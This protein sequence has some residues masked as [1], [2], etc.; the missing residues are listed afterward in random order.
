MGRPVGRW[1]CPIVASVLLGGCYTG[2]EQDPV[3][4]A[5]PDEGGSDSDGTDIPA[6][7]EPA[8]AA[9]RLL[10]QRQHEHAIAD[11]LGPEAAAAASPPPNIALNGFDTVGASQQALSDAEVDAFEESAR[12]VAQAADAAGRLG[13]WV[14]CDPAAI[15]DEA[16]MQEV[17]RGFGRSAWRRALSDEEVERYAAVGTSAAADLGSFGLGVRELIAAMLQS[18]HFIYQVEIGEPDPGD[19]SVRRLTAYEM[20]ARVSFF[21]VDTIPDEELLTDAES[22]LLDDSEGIRDATWRLLARAEARDSVSAFFSELWRLRE[23]DDLPKDT[24]AFPQWTPQLAEAMRGETVALIDDLVWNRDADFREVFTADYTFAD[25]RLGFH[26]GLP[27]ASSLGDELQRVEL[28]GHDKRGGL[29]GHA[30]FQALLAHVSTT[31]PTL[32]GKFVLENVLCQSVP[33]PPPE[34]ITELPDTSDAKTM[35]ERL[36]IHMSDPSCAGCHSVID[37][38]GFG[39]ENYDAIGHFRTTEN[40][41]TIDAAS[42]LYGEDFEGAAQLGAIIADS[43]LAAG[44]LVRN[45]YRHA[46]GHIETDGERVAI[47]ELEAA[48]IDSGYRVQDLIVELVASPSF[49]IVAQPE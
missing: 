5:G 13:D 39:L 16:C 30:G 25:A 35:R 14:P 41:V 4:S 31:S 12:A 45:F 23:L 38:I 9:L 21:V 8:P 49:R 44:C 42:A 28:A 18:P 7:F 29:F 47:A 26:Y 17:A 19:P 43:P 20:A 15:G 36:E 2:L 46:S 10:L 34:V 40:G 32:R 6:E 48:F 24:T 37:P 27:E 11:L 33:P 1:L 3:L 22:G